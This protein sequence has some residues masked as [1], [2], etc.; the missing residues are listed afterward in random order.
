MEQQK[1]NALNHIRDEIIR[2]NREQALF[3]QNSQRTA[4]VSKGADEAVSSTAITRT[5]E[6]KTAF[7]VSGRRQKRHRVLMDMRP[8]IERYSRTIT[9]PTLSSALNTLEATMTRRH[10][11]Y[12]GA[13]P[14]SESHARFWLDYFTPDSSSSRL[15]KAS[16]AAWGPNGFGILVAQGKC[17]IHGLE[18]AYL[19]QQS[20]GVVAEGDGE[21][22]QRG[23]EAEV[24]SEEEVEFLAAV[25]VEETLELG[26][27]DMEMDDLDLSIRSHI[28]RAAMQAAVKDRLERERFIGELKRQMAQK[29]RIGEEEG[30]WPGAEER[31]EM[32]QRILVENAQ[33][34]ARW[35]VSPLSKQ[36]AFVLGPRE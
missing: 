12:P 23:W 29:G 2:L 14:Y 36:F 1:H 33:L 9:G 18:A 16:R 20:E 21:S 5:E 28:P 8:E 32:L 7:G 4:N 34:F 31:G 30:V 13:Q 15:N 17:D 27:E 10:T 25:A 11:A 24:G 26:L 3:Q 19:A 35:R 22:E 6:N